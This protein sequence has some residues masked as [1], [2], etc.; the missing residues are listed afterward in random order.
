MLFY[1]LT[2]LHESDSTTGDVPGSYLGDANDTDIDAGR[3]GTISRAKHAVQEATEALYQDACNH[4]RHNYVTV[5]C[6]IIIF[7]LLWRLIVEDEY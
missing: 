3:R 6:S 4:G 7:N 1:G 2:G 5:Y